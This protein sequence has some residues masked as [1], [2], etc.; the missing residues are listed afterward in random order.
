[1]TRTWV[2]LNTERNRKNKPK[3]GY[4]DR[5]ISTDVYIWREANYHNEQIKQGKYE[6]KKL[7]MV[8][9]PGWPRKI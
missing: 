4:I 8:T 7:G 6:R 2:I 5:F 3:R 1:M 9:C